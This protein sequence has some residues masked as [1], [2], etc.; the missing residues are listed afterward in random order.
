AMRLFATRLETIPAPVPYLA[1][2]PARVAAFRG[3]I[4]AAP[5]LK[6]GLVWAG[7]PTHKNDRNRSLALSALQP[8]LGIGGVSFFSLQMGPREG[9][10]AASGL[11]E[12]IV[13]LAPLLGDFAD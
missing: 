5:G 11:A 2:D 8:L 12:S 10:P 3:R 13:D 1:A 9:E 4:G 6:V 7:R